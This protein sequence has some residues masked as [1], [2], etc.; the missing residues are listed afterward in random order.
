MIAHLI[1]VRANPNMRRAFLLV[2]KAIGTTFASG[3]KEN[4]GRTEDF[5][6]FRIC[7]RC[8]RDRSHAV[9]K[10]DSPLLFQTL[11]VCSGG[12]SPVRL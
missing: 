7:F 10:P 1:C 3:I 9:T 8:R 4:K 6:Y 5:V 11:L 12:A 2:A